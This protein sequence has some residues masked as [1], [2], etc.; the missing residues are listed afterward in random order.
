M[1]CHIVRCVFPWQLVWISLLDIISRFSRA[2]SEASV[3][4]LPETHKGFLIL[5]IKATNC[6]QSEL[7]NTI[8][9]FPANKRVKTNFSRGS[10]TLLA[11][12]TSQFASALV[13]SSFFTVFKHSSHLSP[14]RAQ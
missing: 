1:S 13:A 5:L 7:V 6:N 10:N 12:L 8:I 9:L 11:V 14:H 3:D 2:K 4:I